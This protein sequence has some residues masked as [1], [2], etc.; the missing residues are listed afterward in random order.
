MEIGTVAGR[1]PGTI[2]D[3]GEGTRLWL[4]VKDSDESKRVKRVEQLGWG[5]AAVG[6]LAE[7]AKDKCK[8]REGGEGCRERDR[9]GERE[10]ERERE[11]SKG[12]QCRSE[13]KRIPTAFPGGVRGEW[14]TYFPS[15][16]LLR[17][18]VNPA[19][20]LDICLRTR[21]LSFIPFFYRTQSTHLA[22]YSLLYQC[23]WLY[24]VWSLTDASVT[25]PRFRLSDNYSCL[26]H[27]YSGWQLG[28][29]IRMALTLC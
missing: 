4:S 7:W 21:L 1:E 9:D 12:T 18:G 3:G 8:R 22:F 11:S 28:P 2:D 6:W 5:V 10:R 27:F 23:G 26:L 29:T 25:L 20:A 24:V 16:K 13:T 19:N 17:A 14:I 15:P